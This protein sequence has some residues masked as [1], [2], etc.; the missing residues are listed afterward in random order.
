[1][2]SNTKLQ[3][4]KTGVKS[5]DAFL[6]KEMVKDNSNLLSSEAT[7]TDVPLINQGISEKMSRI[8]EQNPSVLLNN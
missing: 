4:Q 8:K 7:P 1:M 2:N 3:I 5:V 6:T